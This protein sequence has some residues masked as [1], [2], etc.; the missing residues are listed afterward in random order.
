M[1]SEEIMVALPHFTLPEI[2]GALS[3]YY[4]HK[5][6]VDKEWKASLKK[7]RKL[8]SRHPSLLEQKL[9]QIKNLHR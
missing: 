1:T 5:A 3:Y 8:R 9:G 2:H 7:V 4:E 6:E